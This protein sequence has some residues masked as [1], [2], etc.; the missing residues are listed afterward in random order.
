MELLQRAE[1]ARREGRLADA[2]GLV[3][4]VLAIDPRNGLAHLLAGYLHAAARRSDAA[5]SEYRAVLAI[6]PEHPRAMLGLARVDFENGDAAGCR[7]LLERALRVYPDFP[8]A[9]ALLDVT[10]ALAPGASAGPERGPAEA[11]RETRLQRLPLPEGA[12][13]CLLVETDGTLLFSFPASRTREAL[14]THLVRISGIASA[15]LGR[16]GLGPVRRAAVGSN[17]GT[18]YM[19]TDGRLIL[20]LTFGPDTDPNA[21]LRMGGGLWERCM[22]ELG[23]A[24]RSS[25]A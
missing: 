9:R 12:R 5:R 20:A 14:A 2:E 17:S 23:A 6:D 8:E 21:A 1:R 7:K 19:L 3:G 4:E 24:A 10:L 15:V 22:D 13:E 25:H 16:A 18:T 11:S